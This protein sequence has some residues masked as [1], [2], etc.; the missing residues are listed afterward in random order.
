MTDCHELPKCFTI[1]SMFNAVRQLPFPVL[2]IVAGKG[3][4]GESIYGP[5]FEDE[6]FSILH[7][8]RGV[9]GMVNKGYHT[10]GSQFYITLQAT[11]Y[12]DKKYVA[13]GLRPDPSAEDTM[14]GL[15]RALL[16]AATCLVALCVLSAAQN[17][18]LAPILTSATTTNIT[19]TPV[20]SLSPV[21]TPVPDSCENRNSC[22]SCFNTSIDNTTCFWI[23]CKDS[24]ENRNSCVSCFNTSIDNTTC[25]WIDCKDKSPYC[26]SN[27]TVSGCHV[28]NG[29]DFCY[30]TTNTTLTPTSPPAR[31][32]TFDAASFIGGIVLVLGVQ[33]VIFF[34]YK[35]C[36]SKERNYHTL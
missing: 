24:C 26:S 27:S 19:V 3:D 34:L 35:F 14:S 33:A 15:S 2:D 25:F 7:N 16:W 36:K 11:P 30:G 32:S 28:V 12:L 18:T 21:P 13:F 6:N 10:N 23:D 4:D 22:V 9:L 31:K 29:S 20:T 8:K 1:I 17:T 5:T